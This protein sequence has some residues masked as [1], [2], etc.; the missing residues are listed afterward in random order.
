MSGGAAW[1]G[2]GRNSGFWGE[3]GKVACC[4]GL[5]LLASTLPSRG[6]RECRAALC[7]PEGPG[8]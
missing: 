8:S 4:L 7:R 6:P 5:S 3:H 1:D 2:R